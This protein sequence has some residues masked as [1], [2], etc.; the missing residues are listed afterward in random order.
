MTELL[1]RSARFIDTGV[2]DGVDNPT[3]VSINELADNIAMVDA[4]SHVVL[5]DTG[6]GLVAFDTSNPW[7]AKH[8]V[9]AVRQWRPDP[10]RA[11]VY[12][13]GHIDHIGGAKA[14]L[15]EADASGATRPAVVSHEGV[16]ARFARYD[17]TSGYNAI[18]NARQFGGSALTDGDGGL[19]VGRFGLNWVQ[20]STTFDEKMS[21]KVGGLTIELRHGLGETD[22]H[23][24]AW[25]PEHKAACIGDFIIWMF[26]NAGNPQ[27][28]QRYP[29]EWAMVLRE[30]ATFEPELLLPAHGLPVAGKARIAG[31]LDDYASALEYLVDATIGMMNEGARLDDIIHTVRL[32]A[33]LAVK[34]WLAPN[35]DEPEFVVRNIWRRYGG[36][37]DGNPARLKP[38]PDSAVAREVAALAGGVGP[39]ALRAQE[40]SD[41]GDH[42]LACHLA[43]LAVQADPDDLEAHRIRAGIYS[44]RRRTETSLMAKGIY[45]WASGESKR[46]VAALD[47]GALDTAPDPTSD[48]APAYTPGSGDG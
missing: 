17:L 3:T 9:E 8:A 19:K 39:L 1:D 47:P 38:P 33:D 18:I 15:D 7:A 34:P 23:A 27:K 44:A 43:E 48:H 26:P 46:R 30:I 14:F 45:G 22:D 2:I 4:F 31:F 6:D 20:P 40:L 29:R 37:Y 12:T 10:F 11:L 36:W 25:I 42:R 41:A 32:P 28:V 24:W 35:Y 13:H 21:M 5:F 16:P